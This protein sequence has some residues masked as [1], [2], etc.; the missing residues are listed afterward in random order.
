M[1]PTQSVIHEEDQVDIVLAEF[2]DD[3]ISILFI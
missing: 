1:L 3:N 2:H